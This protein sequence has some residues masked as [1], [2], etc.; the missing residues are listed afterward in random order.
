LASLSPCSTP[1][2]IARLIAS[3][4][5][6]FFADAE[7][8]VVESGEEAGCGAELSLSLVV[9]GADRFG[10]GLAGVVG[11]EKYVAISFDAILSADDLL[12]MNL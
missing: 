9:A 7:V 1:S 10:A 12:I 6:L 4:I 8:E 2:A 3:E 5:P 11:F